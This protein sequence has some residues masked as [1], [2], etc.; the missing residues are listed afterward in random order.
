MPLLK[1]LNRIWRNFWLYCLAWVLLVHTWVDEGFV[2]SYLDDWKVGSVLGLIV[3]GSPSLFEHLSGERKFASESRKLL[4][5]LRNCFDRM[6]A[7]YIDCIEPGSRHAVFPFIHMGPPEG[8]N[9]LPPLPAHSET[10]YLTEREGVHSDFSS[11][12]ARLIDGLEMVDQALRERIA[13]DW[14]VLLPAKSKAWKG[15][16]GASSMAVYA[17]IP[18]DIQE[19]A[20]ETGEKAWH[21]V[22]Q[23]LNLEEEWRRLIVGR[24]EEYCPGYNLAAAWPR[25]NYRV[26][27]HI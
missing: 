5:K 11:R 4:T 10:D 26:R 6:Q 3:F 23:Y 16:N 27:P 15:S 19:R 14:E 1:K 25:R 22:S 7:Y 20:T 18:A 2:R 21:W 13:F 17:S 9:S 24:I 8:Y 12:I